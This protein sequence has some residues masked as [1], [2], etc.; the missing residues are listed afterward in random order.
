[1][2]ESYPDGSVP[3]T[4]KMRHNIYLLENGNIKF[5]ESFQKVFGKRSCAV[6]FYFR[7]NR[8]VKEL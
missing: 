7:Y 8:K 4:V 5:L 6:F 1:M 3:L 2:S